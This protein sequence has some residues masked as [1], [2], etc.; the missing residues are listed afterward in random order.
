[1]TDKYEYK[2]HEWSV[3]TRSFTIVADRKLTYDEVDEIYRDS[4]LDNEGKAVKIDS[5]LKIDGDIYLTFNG[6]E[7]GSSEVE[8]DGDFKDDEEE[9]DE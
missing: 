2:V 5:G 7:F 8:T 4:S 6:T 1:M 3:D 9:N